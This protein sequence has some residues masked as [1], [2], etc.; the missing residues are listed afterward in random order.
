[1]IFDVSRDI[2]VSKFLH[3]G[4]WQAFLSKATYKRRAKVICWRNEH[5]L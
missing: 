1:M 3:L 5:Q 4:I 2:V